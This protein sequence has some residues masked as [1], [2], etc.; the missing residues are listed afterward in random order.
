MCFHT[1]KE[2]DYP[3]LVSPNMNIAFSRYM[4]HWVFEVDTAEERANEMQAR[5]KRRVSERVVERGEWERE[6]EGER[7]SGNER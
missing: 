5:E 6:E 7:G 4:D 3:L 2:N 1:H